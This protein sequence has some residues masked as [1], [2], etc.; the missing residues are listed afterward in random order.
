METWEISVG[1]AANRDDEGRAV[2]IDIDNAGNKIDLERLL[3]GSA[4]RPSACRRHHL[5]P[6]S[7]GSYPLGG[8]TAAAGPA[9]GAA[10]ECRA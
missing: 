7:G 8:E 6:P 4:S 5:V 1:V 3:P 2:G 9:V 10:R